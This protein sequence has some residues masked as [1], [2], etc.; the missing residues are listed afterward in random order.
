MELEILGVLWAARSALTIAISSWRVAQGLEEQAF[1]E[2]YNGQCAR[3][4]EALEDAGWSEVARRLGANAAA[5]AGSSLAARRAAAFG[6][7]M[8]PLLYDS[9]VEVSSGEGVW[10]T[11]A[12]GRRYLDAY[13]NVP[14][15]GHGH[16]RVTTA[17]ARQ[18]RRINTHTRYLH[19]S[20]I[21]LAERLIDLCP[22]EA[23]H[24]PFCQLRLGGQRPGVADGD[25][26]HGPRRRAVHGVRLSRD[27]PGDRRPLPGD[28]A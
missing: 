10:I 1:A 8:E 26:G 22:P 24:R 4:I 17:I 12:T 7:T 3:M 14:C 13:N 5:P 21:E 23:R 20:A 27:H 16:P 6:P 18:S 9:P 19:P 2:R 15:V 11:D 25:R 28:V